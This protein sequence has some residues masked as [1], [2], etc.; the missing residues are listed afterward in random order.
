MPFLRTRLSAWAMAV[1]T[2]IGEVV[3]IRVWEDHR[4]Q[5]FIDLI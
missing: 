4:L 5:N 3:G 2:L 1:A